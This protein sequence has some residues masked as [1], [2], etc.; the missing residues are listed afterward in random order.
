MEYIT[1]NIIALI[2]LAISVLTF[3]AGWWNSKG[4]QDRIIAIHRVESEIAQ[5]ETEIKKLQTGL[6]R[7]IKE[8]IELKEEISKL[9]KELILA[10][11]AL[12]EEIEKNVE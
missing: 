4:R 2:A 6:D 11:I 9:K 10:G 8:R 12:K 7:C 1:Q 5:L 3:L